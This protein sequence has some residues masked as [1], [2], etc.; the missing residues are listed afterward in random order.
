MRQKQSGFATLVSHY[1]PDNLSDFK[2]FALKLCKIWQK[3]CSF[4]ENVVTLHPLFVAP[5]PEAL[6][7]T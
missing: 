5:V 4:R 7:L 3:I 2:E 1:Q 6:S